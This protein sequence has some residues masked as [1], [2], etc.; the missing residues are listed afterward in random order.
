[1]EWKDVVGYEGIYEVSDA[2]DV[3]TKEGKTTFTER[4]GIRYWKQ[5]TLKQ[6]VAKDGN[7]RVNLWKDGK[8]RTTLVHRIVAD[9]FIPQ[10][11]G[12]EYVN[13]IDGNRF[14]NCVSNLEWCDHYDNNN[15]AFDND[16]IKTGRKIVLVNKE[17]KDSHYFRSMAKAGHFLGK[18]EGYISSN[19]R[20][21]N[22]DLCGYWIFTQF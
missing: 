1:M 13:H 12:K 3:R 19:L 10:I 22:T 14:N 6:K 16:L 9:A 21:G 4:H 11:T 2:G 17:T 18:N 15:H 20:K 5:R 8:D 7:H